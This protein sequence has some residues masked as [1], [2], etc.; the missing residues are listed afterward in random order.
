[1]MKILIV[2]DDDPT[3]QSYRDNIESFSKSTGNIIEVSVL[4]K[5]EEALDFLA[6][7][8]LDAVIIDLRL[9]S[10]SSELE[11]MQIVEEIYGKLRFPI[12]IVSGS[13][14]QVEREETSFLK[15][16]SRDGSFKDILCEISDIYNT[17][18][19]K[20]LGKRGEIDS[21][22]NNIFWSHISNSL[23]I[24]IDDRSR[25]PVEKQKSLLRYTL[26]HMQEYLELT[27][28]S[29]FDRYHPAEIYIQPSMKENVFTG[30]IVMNSNNDSQCYI[31]LTPSCDLAQSKAKD[32][33]L[34]K[35]ETTNCIL[36]EK[37]NILKR[38]S[39]NTEQL[40]AARTDLT[41]LI[42]N[43]FSN[44]YHFLP[45]Y[46]NLQP[47][48]VNFQKVLS[49]RI[50]DLK[51]EYNVIA[52]VNSSFSKDIIARFSYYYS[53]QGSPDLDYEEVCNSLISG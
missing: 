47:G 35:I 39:G 24:W 34:V 10:N 26:L 46:K 8:E 7:A 19:T 44:K 22:L 41:K 15:K 42:S 53:R 37:I 51:K 30:D 43:N 11:G 2:E 4:K 25:T 27:E 50:G 52:S 38:G 36:N 16:R 31:I 49:I 28:D 29:D 6:T 3:I 1:M 18:I 32:I 40:A 20:I 33:L 13:I 5:L 12:F 17:G 9:S 48:L 14:G 21:Y 45:A 23:D